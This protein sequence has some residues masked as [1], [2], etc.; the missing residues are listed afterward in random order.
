MKI[1]LWKFSFAICVIGATMSSAQG[2]VFPDEI[3]VNVKYAHPSEPMILGDSDGSTIATF[4]ATIETT[5]ISFDPKDMLKLEDAATKEFVSPK[6]E[7]CVLEDYSFS[8]V[9][10]FGSEM[11]MFGGRNPKGSKACQ[12][13]MKAVAIG[14]QM[15]FTNVPLLN[16]G[17]VIKSVIVNVAN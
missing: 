14:F 5:S 4:G 2:A 8:Y 6:L 16:Q 13:F 17:A 3:T 9:G 12:N 7:D 1:V 10:T 15:R 11:L